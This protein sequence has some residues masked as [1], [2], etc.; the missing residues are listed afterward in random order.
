[1][2]RASLTRRRRFA[3]ASGARWDAREGHHPGGWRG[4][5]PGAADRSH[6]QVPDA[7]GRALAAHPDAHGPGERR[8]ARRRPGR[9]SLRRSGPR[10]RGADGRRAH[11]RHVRHQPGI[12]QGLGALALRGPRAPGR[13]GPRDGRRRSL[14]PGVLAPA[15]G[16]TGAQR[17]PHRP[18]LPGHRGGSEVLHPWGPNHRARQEGRAGILGRGGRGCGLLQVRRRGGTEAHS[19]ARARDRGERAQRVR[20]C[21]APAG[22]TTSRRVGGGDGPALDGDRLRRGPAPRAGRGAAAHRPARRRVISEAALYLATPEDASAALAVVA[23]RPLAFRMV[24]AAV[25][26]GCRTVYVPA[27]LRTPELRSALDASPSARPT[28]V[29]LAPN[30]PPPAVSLLLLPAAALVPV[31]ALTPLVAA[32]GSTVLASA[33]DGDA[34]VAVLTPALVRPLWGTVAASQPLGEALVRALKGEPGLAEAQSG[35]F[36][37]V[38]SARAV[39]TAEARLDSELGSPVDTQ[40]DTVFHR[41]LSRPLS[42]LALRWAVSPNAVTVMSLLVG[43]A[44]AWCF[45]NATPAQALVGLALY[46]LAVVLDHADGEVARLG[47]RES[48]WGARL[49]VIVDTAI[50]ALLL[51]A[52]GVTAQRVAGSGAL[53]GVIAGLG[54]AGSA[55]L[56]QSPATGGGG[57]GARLDALS[58]RDGYYAIVILFVLA[59]AFLP[60][61]LPVYMIFIAAGC[62]V[63]WVSQLAYRLTRSLARRYS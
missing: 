21:P 56:A 8:R 34:P 36:V 37:R 23:G 6:P 24:V 41:R 7:G 58:N 22:P 55:V 59:L 33:R 46:A 26:A 52:L 48:R 3:T 44:A 31:I 51:V 40:L 54:A 35:W 16:G 47:L 42:R 43:L 62:H 61:A 14:S 12:R 5:S 25:R 4:P 50:H 63:F 53:A 1:M 20:R 30:L 49:D 2:C 27:A 39:A 15:G 19:A 13:A 45:W 38:P 9:G 60:A 17:V 18:R 32:P 28:V 29:W 11:A 57:I 10:G